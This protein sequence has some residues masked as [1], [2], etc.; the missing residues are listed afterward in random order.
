MAWKSWRV[1]QYMQCTIDDSF[2]HGRWK[3]II[4]VKNFLIVLHSLKEKKKKYKNESIFFYRNG[5]ISSAIFILRRPR[6]SPIVSSFLIL[7]VHLRSVELS[8]LSRQNSSKQC[9]RE[10][11]SNIPRPSFP[12]FWWWIAENETKLSAAHLSP[13]PSIDI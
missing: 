6:I 3:P 5:I 7:E 13:I 11:Y 10:V 9:R 4:K 12:S 1:I 8:R 2:G